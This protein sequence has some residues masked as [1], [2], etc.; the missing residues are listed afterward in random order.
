MFQWR[1]RLRNEFLP[2]T[3]WC[4]SANA[5]VFY[6]KCLDRRKQKEKVALSSQN[7]PYEVQKFI[8][9]IDFFFRVFLRGIILN[10]PLCTTLYSYD[11]LISHFLGRLGRHR[12]LG[13]VRPFHVGHEQAHFLI[14]P[15]PLRVQ[16]TVIP[17][18][19]LRLDG[20]RVERWGGDDREKRQSI[21]DSEDIWDGGTICWLRL[22]LLHDRCS[23][24]AC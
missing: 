14:G 12:T 21:S 7:G 8:N 10:I 11:G 5:A 16:L 19:H 4:G 6:I 22:Q 15:P 17:K 13:G 20:R 1:L 9:M 23:Q 3:T 18:W 2:K 24:A